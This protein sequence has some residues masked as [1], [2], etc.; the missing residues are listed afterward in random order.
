MA[1]GAN[2]TKWCLTGGGVVVV[3]TQPPRRL[4]SFWGTAGPRR[5]RGPPAHL[6]AGEQRQARAVEPAPGVT[7]RGL[8][9]GKSRRAALTV[10]GKPSSGRED[11]IRASFGII[12][13]VPVP[14]NLL[15]ANKKRTTDGSRDG[16]EQRDPRPV[17][18]KASC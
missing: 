16:T 6:D 8:S 18:C 1:E 11:R 15:E 4:P 5:P 12:P 10:A 17:R 13:P 7:G 3:R 2:R 14:R 9:W